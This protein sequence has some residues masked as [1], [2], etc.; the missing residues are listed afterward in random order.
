MDI[1]WQDDLVPVNPLPQRVVDTEK[2]FRQQ[3]CND[4]GAEESE[5]LEDK[6]TQTVRILD[7][8]VRYFQ[9]ETV[10]DTMGR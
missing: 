9:V 7:G 4:R 3:E 6:D 10:T 8:L 5:E 1:S 2:R